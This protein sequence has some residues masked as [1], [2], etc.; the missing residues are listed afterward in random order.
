LDACGNAANCSQTITVFD[1]TP[2]NIA[3]VNPLFVPGGTINIQC[4]GQDPAWNVPTFDE[5]SIVAS[6]VCAGEIAIEYNETL[7]QAGDCAVNGFINRYRLTWTATDVCGNSSTAFVFLA[8]IDTIAPTIV[9]V[10][11]DISINCDEIPPPPVNLV[12]V[13][14]CLCACILSFEESVT[15]PGCQDGQV[16]VRSWTAID[17]CGNQTTVTQDIELIDNAG[18]NWFVMVPEIMG[19]KRDT[20]LEYPCSDGFPAYLDYLNE[21]FVLGPNSCGDAFLLAFDVKTQYADNCELAGYTEQRTY[22]WTAVDACGNTSS[23]TILARLTDHEP[24]VITGILPMACIGDTLNMAIATDNCSVPFIDFQDTQISSPCGNGKAV[25]RTFVATD[26]CG[27]VETATTILLPSDNLAPQIWFTNPVLEGLGAGEAMTMDCAAYNGQYTSFGINDVGVADGC[28]TGLEVNFTETLITA[29]DCVTNGS[30]AVIELR[31][32]ATDICGN[33]SELVVIANIMDESGPVFVNFPAELTIACHDTLPELLV[34]DN[35]GEVSLITWDTI[36]PSD[37]IYEYDLQRTVTATD[38]CGNTTTQSQTVHVGDGGGPVIT[39]VLPV[40]CDD[41][42]VPVVTAYDACAGAF[43]EVLME[44]DT[45]Q[46]LCGGLAIDRTW[47]ATG[48]CGHETVVHQSIII[49]DTTPPVIII[50]DLSFIH[51]FYGNANNFVFLSQTALIDQLNGL[52]NGSVNVLNDCGEVVLMV[53]TTYAEDCYILGY[54]EQRR[55]TWTATDA[56]GNTATLSFVVNIMDDIPP[57]IV[58]VPYE[59]LIVCIELPPAPTV[60]VEGES[61]PVKITYTEVIES[62]GGP[63]EYVVTRTWVATDACGNVSVYTQVIK[64]IPDSF[65]E[66]SIVVPDLVYCNAHGILVTSIIT[67]GNGPFNYDWEIV[68]EECFIKGGQGTPEINIYMGWTDA[69]IILTVTDANGCV[70]VCTTTVS[71][72]FASG[73]SLDEPKGIPS[74]FAANDAKQDCLRQIELWPNPANGNVNLGFESSVEDIV[75][76]SV[77]NFL[78]KVVFADKINAKMGLN[79]HKLDMSQLQEGSYLVQ[80]KTNQEVHTKVVVVMHSN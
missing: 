18:P 49:N 30:V 45:L 60:V 3:F 13:D 72:L 44:D 37:C 25:E 74:T 7:E 75:T 2:P 38:L 50:P 43:V 67:G 61:Q 29:G 42:R 1:N 16:I 19:I 54:S 62:N 70:S 21:E 48:I 51:L 80:V 76:F 28:M 10:P 52:N 46:T 55:Y 63:G 23:L 24:P 79:T 57:V 27:N 8:L 58:E 71:C 15:L 64:W 14:E 4:Y 31:W 41:I 26:G 22:H 66:C 47:S 33:L 78:G 6:D 40:I 77:S 53:T 69:I 68:G 39:G 17:Q 36:I 59:V 12:G 9:G 65:L 20:I 35:C 73:K 5:G 32:T 56:C 11:D 34:T